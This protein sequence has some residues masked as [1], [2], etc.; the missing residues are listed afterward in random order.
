MGDIDIL[1]KE[2]HREAARVALKK[3]GFDCDAS[4]GAVREFSR[5]GVRLE[6]HTDSVR[7]MV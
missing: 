4:N 3:A 6:V 2:R 5:S 7:I 1:I